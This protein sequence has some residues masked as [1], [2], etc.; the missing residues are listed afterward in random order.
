MKQFLKDIRAYENILVLQQYSMRD[1]GTNIYNLLLDG[2][3]TFTLYQFYDYLIE[4]PNLRLTITAP[5]A[6]D[7]KQ[8]QLLEDFLL[9]L[10][11]GRVALLYV[12]YGDSAKENKAKFRKF[13]DFG[14]SSDKYYDLVVNYFAFFSNL[15]DDDKPVPEIH[16]FLLS[17]H[18]NLRN[19]LFFVFIL[20]LVSE[21]S[22]S[23]LLSMERVNCF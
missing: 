23:N 12:D 17:A 8:K 18:E 19:T 21:Q 9:K 6:H 5:K 11:K 10:F 3:L 16:S 14:I 20:F 15:I 2:N 1:Q 13:S 7:P 22:F 4:N